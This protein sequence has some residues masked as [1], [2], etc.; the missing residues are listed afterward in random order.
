[1]GKG[2]VYQWKKHWWW[3]WW[4]WWWQWKWEKEWQ[5][6][7]EFHHWPPLTVWFRCK[8]LNKHRM[9]MLY[10]CTTLCTTAVMQ[11]VSQCDTVQFSLVLWKPC[12]SIV[13]L[14]L[15]VRFS[16]GVKSLATP[17]KGGKVAFVLLTCWC[18]AKKF[19][20]GYMRNAHGDAGTFLQSDLV[21]G[22]SHSRVRKRCDFVLLIHTH[23]DA[24][25]SF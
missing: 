13:M 16:L 1:M 5:S 6:S 22:Q 8:S 10:Y 14:R 12:L 20:C 17:V 19:F 25:T 15:Q 4:W 9:R 21:L 3:Q 24:G 7:A 23:G 11:C 2:N 18:I